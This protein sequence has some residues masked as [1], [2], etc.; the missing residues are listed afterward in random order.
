MGLGWEMK[1]SKN[2]V[3]IFA[4]V[5]LS[6]C[7][8]DEQQE[9]GG[10][11]TTKEHKLEIKGKGQ[12]NA[13]SSNSTN[14]NVNSNSNSRGFLCGALSNDFEVKQ[15]AEQLRI[16]TDNYLLIDKV[17]LKED[18]LAAKME[19]LS[20]SLLSNG[21]K[22]ISTKPLQ[23]LIQNGITNRPFLFSVEGSLSQAL[24]FFHALG[25]MN[26]I[27][28]TSLSID[29][30]DK[31]RVVMAMEISF[32][33]RGE[34]V[35]AIHQNTAS[36]SACLE[37]ITGKISQIYGA[38]KMI[39]EERIQKEALIVFSKQFSD[40]FNDENK[41]I[42]FNSLILKQEPF[43][44]VDLKAQIT[45]RKYLSNLTN[46][47]LSLT[48]EGHNVGLSK[49]DV[50]DSKQENS[51]SSIVIASLPFIVDETVN[52]LISFNCSIT[53]IPETQS[54]VLE[55]KRSQNP[56]IRAAQ[57]ELKRLDIYT[58]SIDGLRGA[59]TSRAIR[60]F[61]EST[62]LPI[63][64]VVNRALVQQMR[65]T[66]DNAFSNKSISN[67]S[68]N[69]D[70][71]VNQGDSAQSDKEVQNSNALEEEKKPVNSNGFIRGLNSLFNS[72]SQSGDA[73]LEE[74]NVE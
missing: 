67:D 53:S 31:E 32:P 72:N 57:I 8:N 61:Q 22:I 2:I 44:Q 55:T 26:N 18:E 46:S 48:F 60:T 4:F 17:R 36:K 27:L 15:S 5:F 24:A 74:D 28:V 34:L 49:I 25:R 64:G 39:Q 69:Q 37:S 20:Q 68:V 16:V 43:I 7:G 21:L 12:N 51:S 30:L 35:T 38:T 42:A 56:L 41:C 23:S 52:E 54:T 50:I 47:L 1:I 11:K 65:D 73:E 33:I 9:T 66:P 6:A 14:G 59:N 70:D 45:E 29:Q 10:R 13:Q 19:G 40:V 58:S 71:S 3:L 62:G 63:T